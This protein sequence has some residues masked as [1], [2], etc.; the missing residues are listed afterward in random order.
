MW[1]HL[2][3]VL[4]LLD[5]S[6]RRQG[7]YLLCSHYNMMLPTPGRFDKHWWSEWVHVPLCPILCTA[8]APQGHPI[9]K[10]STYVSQASSLTPTPSSGGY[11]RIPEPVSPTQQ[12]MCYGTDPRCLPDPLS[13]GACSALCIQHFP[14]RPP[15][16]LLGN[17]YINWMYRVGL[18]VRSGWDRK[19][20]MNFLANLIVGWSSM[21]K[22]SYVVFFFTINV[23][24]EI[25]HEACNLALGEQCG[26]CMVKIDSSWKK[27]QNKAAIIFR[28]ISLTLSRSA[29]CEPGLCPFDVFRHNRTLIRPASWHVLLLF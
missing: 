6:P 20:Q 7:T 27:I 1:N 10:C 25:F 15:D 21:Q 12:H 5:R 19:T 9:T 4:S 2:I 24:H 29:L 16:I 26:S 3:E 11:P 23:F 14:P 8:L 28:G 13:W 17:R 22:I 18:K